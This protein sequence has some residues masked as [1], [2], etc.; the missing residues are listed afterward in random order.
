M[1]GGQWREAQSCP[2]KFFGTR[3][4]AGSTLAGDGS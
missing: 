4:F 3:K 2:A 1:G